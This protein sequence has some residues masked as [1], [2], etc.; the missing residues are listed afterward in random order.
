MR[1]TCFALGN[2]A[3][4]FNLLIEF[5]LSDKQGELMPELPV[6]KCFHLAL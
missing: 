3:Q 4:T 6:Q 2:A 1:V 5:S